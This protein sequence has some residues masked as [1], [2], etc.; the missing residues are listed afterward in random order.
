MGEV[1]FNWCALSDTE[2]FHCIFY[3]NAV[4]DSII[5]ST[6]H[7]RAGGIYIHKLKTGHIT[8]LKK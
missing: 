4:S 6:I 8:H 2:I 7:N 5:S 3:V 1:I